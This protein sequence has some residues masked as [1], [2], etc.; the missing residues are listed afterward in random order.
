MNT[1]IV[2][3]PYETRMPFDYWLSKVF[4]EKAAII[5]REVKVVNRSLAARGLVR[6]FEE[7]VFA[8]HVVT[9]H[10]PAEMWVKHHVFNQLKLGDI[11]SLQYQVGRWSDSIKAKLA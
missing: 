6:V 1:A 8:I 11:V 10:G 7:T 9:K 4:F 2:N 5:R 3:C